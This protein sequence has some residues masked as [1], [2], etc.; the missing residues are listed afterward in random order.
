MAASYL[1]RALREQPERE[2]REA[3]RHELGV[4]E[5]RAGEIDAAVRDLA[6]VQ[7]TSDDRLRRAQAGRDLGLALFQAGRF[8]DAVAAQSH[9]MEDA[10]GVDRDLAAWLTAERH[11]TAM[12]DPTTYRATGD[13][14]DLGAD[15]AGETGGERALLAVMGAEATFRIDWGAH[16]ALRMARDA[17]AGGLLADLATSSSGV[18]VI[19]VFPFAFGDRLD[20]ALRLTSDMV[21]V[22]RVRG[23]WVGAVRA[24][25]ARAMVHFLLGAV[26]DAE[27][28]ARSAYELGMD[29]RLPPARM[30]AGV[31]LEA[32]A[33][34]GTSDEGDRVLSDLGLTGD[35]PGD[36]VGLWELHGRAR[37]RLAQGRIDAAITDFTELDR[38]AAG[39][40][41][42]NPA[43]L[44][45]RSRLA[46]ALLLS[47]DRAG[48]QRAAAEELDL[49]R[50]WGAARAIGIALRALGQAKAGA[51]GLD[52]LTESTN[53]LRGSQAQLEYAHSLVAYGSALRR[54][55]RRADARPPLAEGLDLARRCG[56]TALAEHA[57]TELRAAGARPR[58]LTRTGIDALT[59]S[60]LRVARMAADGMSNPAI[61][62]ALFVTLR[63]VE[64]HL[65]HTYTKLGISSRDQ[66]P[67]AL[68]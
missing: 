67:A 21:G 9:A 17:F 6:D 32:V 41:T 18:G 58:R 22:A 10:G 1:R 63:T 52:L 40:R 35:I 48:A 64:V 60:E 62:Q 3:V 38:R 36:V 47:G 37:L 49:A 23:S 2:Q 33:E 45:Y 8:A 53:V 43:V 54:D 57:H 5:F 61:A 55:G 34:R 31:F 25:L 4:A 42:W 39:W 44:P 14:L 68:D 51:D 46:M 7:R 24:Y 27:S 12:M 11:Q 16:L 66:L 65:T 56:A 59:P 50:Q 26:R 30:A 28:D 29:I 13:L 19:A 20:E 15:I